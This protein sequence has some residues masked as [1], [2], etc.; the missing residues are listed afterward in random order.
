MRSLFL[1]ATLLF[2]DALGAKQVE[3]SNFKS[4]LACTR[5]TQVEGRDGW[6]CQP[7]ELILVTDQGSCVFNKQDTL[8]T[9]IGFEFDYSSTI[10]GAKLQCSSR[11]SEPG[12]NGNPQEILDSDSSTETYEIELPGRSGHFYNPQYF[13]FN[14]Q[15]VAD[16]DLVTETTCTSDGET[17][18]HFRFQ[19][20]FPL[21]AAD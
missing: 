17:V 7:T 14:L 9:W 2:S 10:D 8:C 4:G 11:S 13:V 1:V 20:H 18:V 21:V 19:L 3:I 5:S 16:E 12:I 15:E 6:I